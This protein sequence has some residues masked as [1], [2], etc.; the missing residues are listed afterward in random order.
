VELG[1]CLSGCSC[2]LALGG[3]LIAVC[4]PWLLALCVVMLLLGAA[5]SAAAGELGKYTSLSGCRQSW[6]YPELSA[7]AGG[8]DVAHFWLVVQFWLRV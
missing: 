6:I 1:C 5:T 4:G 7:Q 2:S 8:L 3:A